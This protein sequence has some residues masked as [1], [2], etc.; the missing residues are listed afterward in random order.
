MSK[1]ERLRLIA[2]RETMQELAD[3]ALAQRDTPE[4][5]IAGDDFMRQLM[6][7][8]CPAWNTFREIERRA[9]RAMLAHSRN[10]SA[11]ES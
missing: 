8:V 4:F 2:S 11:G 9:A 5:A 6:A 7:H 3:I 1:P 10:R